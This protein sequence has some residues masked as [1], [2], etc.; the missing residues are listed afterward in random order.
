M[1]AVPKVRRV[2]L[3]AAAEAD[4]RNILVWIS[5]NFGAKQARTCSATLSITLRE[6]TK[7]PIKSG[8]TPR[9]D[10]GKRIYA[11]HVARHGRKG[12][13]FVVFRVGRGIDGELIDVLRLL[14]DTMDLPR[15]IPTGGESN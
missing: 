2:R 4:F 15:H 9:D 8:A 6:L 13:H 7:G 11:L 1:T 14:H 12:R 3:A 10:I 5:G